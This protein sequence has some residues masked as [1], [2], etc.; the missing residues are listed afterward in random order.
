MRTVGRRGVSRGVALRGGAGAAVGSWWT[1][2]GRRR[3]GHG[4]AKCSARWPSTC[5]GPCTGEHTW[6]MSG[7][8][9]GP[10]PRLFDSQTPSELGFCGAPGRIRTCDHR[11]RSPVLS[12]LYVPQGAVSSLSTR[13]PPSFRAKGCRPAPCQSGTAEHKRSTHRPWWHSMAPREVLAR[14]LLHWCVLRFSESDF[15]ILGPRDLKEDIVDTR[16]VRSSTPTIRQTSALLW[17]CCMSC[18]YAARSP[19]SFLWPRGVRS[20][21]I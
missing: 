15:W 11:M 8:D 19:V 7:P 9:P 14:T 3:H 4:M 18:K 12:C 13:S 2:T 16:P 17:P 20:L 21:R 1:D 10:A 5:T 6:R